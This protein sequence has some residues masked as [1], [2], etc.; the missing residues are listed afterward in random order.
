M[1]SM[2]TLGIS[3]LLFFVTLGLMW[4]VGV[5][6]LAELAEALPIPAGS[7]TDTSVEMREQ[8]QVIM[9][10]VPAVLIFFGSIKM[11]ASAAA[12]GSD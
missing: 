3:F 6:V 1:A 5:K 9:I 4:L 11:L 8:I 2:I 10:W 7:W 12:R